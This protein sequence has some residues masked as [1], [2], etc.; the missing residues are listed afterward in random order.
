MPTFRRLP[1]RG[2][3]NA[4]FKVRYSVVNLESLEQ[5]FEAGAHVT[6]Q[7]L[8]ESG[9]IRNEKMPVKILGNGSLTKKLTIDANKFSKSAQAKIESAG[10]KVNVI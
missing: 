6:V 3:T 5:K 1:K 8:R 2:F 9:L 10:G 7:V 4:L